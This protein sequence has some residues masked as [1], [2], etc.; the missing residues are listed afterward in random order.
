[1]RVV[2]GRQFE[3]GDLTPRRA[4]SQ[5]IQQAFELAGVAL[6]NRDGGEQGCGWTILRECERSTTGKYKYSNQLVERYRSHEHE[7]QE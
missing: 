4:T 2:T 1:V 3:A 6:I 7:H 5:V